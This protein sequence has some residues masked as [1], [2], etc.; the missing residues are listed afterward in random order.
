MAS[1]T[2]RPQNPHQL[3]AAM[4]AAGLDIVRLARA[5]GVTKQFISLLLQGKRGCQPT[6]AEAIAQAIG[7]PMRR[8]FGPMLYEQSH[9][10]R[11][12]MITATSDPYLTFEEV[13]DLA[14]LPVKTLRHL[15]HTGHGPEFFKIGRRLKIRESKAREWIQAYENGTATTTP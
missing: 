11:E 2:L 9:N 13:A 14:R 4:Y 8:F 7:Q 1:P 12:R 10:E 15:R 3:K 5:A 6:T